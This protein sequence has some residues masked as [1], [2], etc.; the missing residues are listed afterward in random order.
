MI[1]RE[2]REEGQ[3]R[4]KNGSLSGVRKQ[5]KE[6]PKEKDRWQ[7]RGNE[8]GGRGGGGG[9]I[10]EEDLY[11]ALETESGDSSR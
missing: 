4:A 9:Y 1:A 6:R 8:E 5:S 2:P 10:K 7:I 11:P 3:A